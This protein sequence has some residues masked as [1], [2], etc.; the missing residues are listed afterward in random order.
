MNDIK[1]ILFHLSS[2]DETISKVNTEYKPHLLARYTLD[3]CQMINSFY[4]KYHII[5]PDNDSLTAARV[6]V[7]DQVKE[8]LSDVMDLL[9]VAKIDVM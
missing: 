4:Q 5:N 3:L 2:Y 1:H 7:L 6:A 9:G 8:V